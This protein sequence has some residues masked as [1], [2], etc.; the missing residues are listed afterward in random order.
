VTKDTDLGWNPALENA[1]KLV[2]DGKL[3]RS[4]HFEV[5]MKFLYSYHEQDRRIA[6][7]L[8][9]LYVKLNPDDF[10]KDLTL[11]D[12]VAFG[13]ILSNPH[14]ADYGHHVLY[15][16]LKN[17]EVTSEWVDDIADE[18]TKNLRLAFAT[19]L[20]E[21]AKRKSIPES[22]TLGMCVYFI[23]QP[24]V[25]VRDM[26]AEALAEIGKRDPEKL[27]YFLAEQEQ[28]AGGYRKALIAFV[29]ELM[30]WQKEK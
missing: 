14:W 3:N 1:E 17:R 30:G 28:G 29:R 5:F 7:A 11:E 21:L 4:Q 18:G 19:A 9:K 15:E 25:E 20:V 22:R 26:V 27:H 8:L 10:D 16:V 6:L 12:I 23:D 2:S 24:E 13:N